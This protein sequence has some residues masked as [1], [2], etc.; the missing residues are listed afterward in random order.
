[1]VIVQYLLMYLSVEAISSKEK[2]FYSY[3]I[4]RHGLYYFIKQWRSG[5]ELGRTRNNSIVFVIIFKNKNNPTVFWTVGR[6]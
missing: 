1:M 6:A 2:H 3:I 5:K 4:S